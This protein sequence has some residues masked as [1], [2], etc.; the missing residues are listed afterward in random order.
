MGER[1]KPIEAEQ[2]VIGAVLIDPGVLPLVRQQVRIEDFTDDRHR[3]IWRTILDLAQTFDPIDEVTV[4]SRIK[5]LG[6]V[7]QAGGPLYLAELVERVP[8]VV[9]IEHYAEIIRQAAGVRAIYKA[10]RDAQ[11]AI[12]GGADTGEVFASL[13]RVRADIESREPD[14]FGDLVDDF[15]GLLKEMEKRHEQGIAV[16]T[17][18]FVTTGFSS[19]DA[20]LIGFGKGQLV[21]LSGQSGGGKT[22]LALNCA[23]RAVLADQRVGFF[24]GEMSRESLA[25]RVLSSAAKVNHHVLRKGL[26]G[27]GDWPR[28]VNARAG[29]KRGRFAINDTITTVEEVVAMAVR[30]HMVEP[31]DVIFVDYLQRLVPRLGPRDNREQVVAQSAVDLKNLARRLQVPVVVLSQL[32]SDG[33]LRESK[34]IFHEADVV[35]E[36]LRPGM[37]DQDADQHEASVKINKQRDGES[38]VSVPLIWQG[39]YVRFDEIA[40]PYA[41][42]PSKPVAQS[43]HEKLD[44]RD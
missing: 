38:G 25:R 26:M 36:V 16:S 37:N 14:R 39:Q 42:E 9:N 12:E 31:F 11:K 6:K 21:I 20:K 22:A 18:S 27:D 17:E 10:A 28:A 1:E 2:S 35:I 5:R 43:W 29:F 13:A 23:A 24:S 41:P 19:I 3:L 15:D 8:S 33:A 30:S 32:N 44:N 34:A 4:V 40:A 7:D